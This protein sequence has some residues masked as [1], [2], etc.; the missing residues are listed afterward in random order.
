[1]Y[2]KILVPVDDSETSEAG[3]DEALRLAR[4]CG[5]RLRLLHISDDLPF[6]SEA[7]LY[8]PQPADLVSDGVKRGSALLARLGEQVAAQ[9]IDVD[10][11]LVESRGRH[12][13][14]FVNEQAQAWGAEV[15]VLGTHGR[16]GVERALVGSVAEQVVRHAE[17]PVLLVRRPE[18][19]DDT[20]LQSIAAAIA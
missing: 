1:M 5:G 16:R 19:P 4:L 10:T 17:V 12:L 8:H 13:H 18:Y 14:D 15:V 11:V 3:L 6:V 2:A 9:G 20:G 7:A